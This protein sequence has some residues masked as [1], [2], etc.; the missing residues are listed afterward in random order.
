DNAAT[1]ADAVFAAPQPGNGLACLLG[2]YAFAIQIYGD[3]G[4][5]SLIARGLARLLGFEL[6][7]NF[8]QPY[9]AQDPTDFCGRWHISLSTCTRD[10]LYA[11]LGGNR[12][13]TRSTLVNLV[14]TMLLGGL[15]HGAAW[16]YVVWGLYHGL[17]LV[18]FRLW[19]ARHS[20]AEPARIRPWR[21]AAFFQL[22]CFGWLIFRCKGLAQAGAFLVEIAR[23]GSWALGP[24]E[25][26]WLAALGLLATPVLVMDLAFE[27]GERLRSLGAG[28]LRAS[29]LLRGAY[30]AA[31]LSMIALL[32]L[33]GDRGHRAFIYF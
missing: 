15:W 14:L 5:Y 22:T 12:R 28:P 2:I 7:V 11:P 32:F 3:F 16:K 26:G 30:A 23:P 10:S 27:H 21:A 17:L 18:A 20:A 4:G 29:L 31:S 25:V 9:F 24:A 8:R 13:G 1:I 6:M 19:P 33:L